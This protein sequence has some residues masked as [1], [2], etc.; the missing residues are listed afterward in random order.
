V[1]YGHQLQVSYLFIGIIWI[2]H[3]DLMRFVD[4]LTSKLISINFAH[5]LMGVA[6]AVCD[7]MDRAQLSPILSRFTQQSSCA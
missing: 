6:P 1:A 3:H 2:N 5:L 7:G 4:C